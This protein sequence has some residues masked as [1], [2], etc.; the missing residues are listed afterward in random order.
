[1]RSKERKL[2]FGLTDKAFGI[3]DNKADLSDSNAEA[4]VTEDTIRRNI[5]K[6]SP[7]FKTDDHVLEA[8]DDGTLLVMNKGTAIDLLVPADDATSEIYVGFAVS[9]MK[10]GAG[11]VTITNAGGVTI[12]SPDGN[13]SITT[14]YAGASL[15]KIDSNE[16]WL[17]GDL[18]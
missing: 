17:S 18:A 16:W 1:M 4:L 7:Q 14:Q 11:N 5:N 6:L 3:T 2:Y 10:Y 13:T 12:N 15:I 9:I 8:G